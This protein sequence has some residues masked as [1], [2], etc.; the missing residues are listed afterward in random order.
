MEQN[1]RWQALLVLRAQ[2][3]QDEKGGTVPSGSPAAAGSLAHHKF[4]RAARFD[5]A[6]SGWTGWSAV[7]APQR[8]LSA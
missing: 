1:Q 2:F 8:R 5:E 7:E 3:D 4:R 6:L